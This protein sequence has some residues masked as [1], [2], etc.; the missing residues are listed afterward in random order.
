MSSCPDP[1]PAGDI[2]QAPS[3]NLFSQPDLAQYKPMNTVEETRRIKLGILSKRHGGMNFLS[4]ALG[5]NY[6][7]LARIENAN[8]RHERGGAPYVM[9]SNTARS[10]EEKLSL[11]VGWM[12]TPATYAEIHGDDDPRSKAE[13][14]IAGM[15]K[16]DLYTAIR[17]LDALKKP[18]PGNGTNGLQ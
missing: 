14:L 16:D 6:A 15:E 18:I 5:M 10:I 13:Q 11:P 7:A 2:L 9:G 8:I 4:K 3:G 12:D 17:L 1:I